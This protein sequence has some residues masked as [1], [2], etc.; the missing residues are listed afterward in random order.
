MQIRNYPPLY[1][2]LTTTSVRY[3]QVLPG[4]TLLL[5]KHEKEPAIPQVVHSV[6]QRGNLFQII[7]D[8]NDKPGQWCSYYGW[9]DRT[10]NLV[11]NNP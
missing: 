7:L 5:K 4:D 9:G 10:L 8:P 11:T 2:I 3:D 6:I 1:I